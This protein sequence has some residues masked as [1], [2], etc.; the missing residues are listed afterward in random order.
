MADTAHLGS[1]IMSLRAVRYPEGPWGPA[2]AVLP[3]DCTSGYPRQ[4]LGVE[5]HPQL[6]DDRSLA[7]TYFNP[8]LALGESPVRFVLSACFERGSP[9]PTARLAFG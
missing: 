8:G 2:V 1:G 3:P 6:G 5:I 7:L 4:C 9:R